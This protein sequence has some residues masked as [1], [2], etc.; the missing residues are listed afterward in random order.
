[1]VIVPRRVSI[2]FDTGTNF[3]Y[4]VICTEAFGDGY[5]WKSDH[6][7]PVDNTSYCELSFRE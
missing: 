6:R 5:N 3:T 4:P 2:D 7:D 1:M